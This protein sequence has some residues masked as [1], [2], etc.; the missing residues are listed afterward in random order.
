M[1]IHDVILTIEHF[2]VYMIFIMQMSCLLIKFQATI[3]KYFD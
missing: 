1:F 3:E 2:A